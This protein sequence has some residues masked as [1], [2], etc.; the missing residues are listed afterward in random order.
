MQLV[1]FAPVILNVCQA[2]AGR[3]YRALLLEFIVRN[4][5]YW[6]FEHLARLYEASGDSLGSWEVPMA[7]IVNRRIIESKNGARNF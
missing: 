2:V 6:T 5:F 1:N 7:H 3:N 4:A